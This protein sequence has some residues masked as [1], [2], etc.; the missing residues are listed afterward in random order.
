[1]DNNTLIDTLIDAIAT[2]VL[3]KIGHST[4]NEELD[5]IREEMTRMHNRIATLNDETEERPT[6][7]D[8]ADIIR[9]TLSGASLSIDL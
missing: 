3:A 8:V 2:A 5:M 7:D 9:D 1:M 4:I 6:R